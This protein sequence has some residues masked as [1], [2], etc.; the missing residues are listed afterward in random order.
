MENF[1]IYLIGVGGQGI[2]L[3][4]EVLTRAAFYSQT[5]VKA[6]D[7][8]GLAQRGG[9]VTS[10]IK[11]GQA[12]TPLIS[13]HNA[14]LVL[15]LEINEALRGMNTH[16]KD[17]GTL[18]YY[19]TEWQ[20]L[21]VRLKEKQQDV[22]K[23]IAEEAERRNIR[24]IGTYKEDLDDPRMENVVVLATLSREK[25]IPEIKEAHIKKAMEDLMPP[26]ILQKNLKVFEEEKANFSRRE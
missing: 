22:K 24:K 18:V 13:G 23:A 8:H 16:L 5:D 17:G 9:T 2:G 20:P 14:D 1:D 19:D 15:A 3:L 4:S 26:K 21:S 10:Q 11:L 7:T 6:V 12:F 25:L